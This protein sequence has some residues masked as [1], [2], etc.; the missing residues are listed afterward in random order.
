LQE[1]LLNNGVFAAGSTTLRE[2]WWR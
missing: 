2:N 1:K